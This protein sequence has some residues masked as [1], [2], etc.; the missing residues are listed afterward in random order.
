MKNRFHIIQ[1]LIDNLNYKRYLEIGTRYAPE[2]GN[3]SLDSIKCDVRVGVDISNKSATY[4][5]SSD[6]FF[7]MIPH[8][9]RYDII[10]IDGDH[11]KGQ[12]YKD[13]MNSLDHL[14][15]NGIIVCHDI[16]PTFERQLHPTKC[17]NAW[18]TWALLR[19]SRPDLTMHALNIDMLGIIS[20]G[21]QD[22][23]T[24]DITY[25]WPYLND[26]RDKLLNVISLEQFKQ[27]YANK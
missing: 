20:R 18:E 15:E 9:D 4:I 14:S 1:Y 17:G 2:S 12:V 26:N 6:D 10:F 25:S 16:N 5:M 13:I 27:I 24:D 22:I 7:K 19:Q 8:D 23:Y 21:S 3:N 11:E